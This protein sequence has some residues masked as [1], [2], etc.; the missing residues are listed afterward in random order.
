MTTVPLGEASNYFG[1]LLPR[2]IAAAAQRGVAVAAARGVQRIVTQIIPARSPQPVD[3]GVYRAG[4]RF[5][6]R[7]DRV[8]IT[9]PEVHAAFIEYGVRPENVKIGAAMIQALK[10]WT[11][12][13]GI[14]GDDDEATGIAWAIAQKAKERGFFNRNGQ[15]G[16]QVLT[17][18]MEDH[19][20]RML[21]EEINREIQKEMR[22]A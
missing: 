6:I 22:R 16:L 9:N 11:I 10:E 2:R 1:R 21:E 17:E 20:P 18:L 14:A 7:G 12:R 8:F 3:R 4:W 5:E 13:K 19:M 15:Q